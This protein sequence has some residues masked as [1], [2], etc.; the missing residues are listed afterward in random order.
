MTDASKGT[1]SNKLNLDDFVMIDGEVYVM[2]YKGGGK[3]YPI[4]PRSENEKKVQVLNEKNP[5]LNKTL[6]IKKL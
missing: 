1:E 5:E 4:R 3:I 2:G 6:T